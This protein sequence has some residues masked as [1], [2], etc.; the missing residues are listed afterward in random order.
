[1][2]FKQ[3]LGLFLKFITMAEVYSM[4][5]ILFLGIILIPSMFMMESVPYSI[6]SLQF[7]TSPVRNYFFL[8]FIILNPV[9]PIRPKPSKTKVAGSGIDVVDV[10]RIVPL[11]PTAYP[12]FPGEK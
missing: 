6:L 8:R 2:G 4:Q 10:M 5:E 11:S 9:I 1:V 7:F 3:L 12:I